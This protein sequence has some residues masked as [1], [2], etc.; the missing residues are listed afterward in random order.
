M[1]IQTSMTVYQLADEAIG[2]FLEYRDQHGYT[3]P[4]ARAAAVA[5][6][7]DGIAAEQELRQMGEI[8]P[9]DP[10]D[11]DQGAGPLPPPPLPE[12]RPRGFGQ[13]YDFD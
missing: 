5:E 1:A 11:V 3:E 7:N 4:A 2:L 10:A 13:V 12:A 9:L 6:V 8:P